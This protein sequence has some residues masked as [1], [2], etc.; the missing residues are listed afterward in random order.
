V[1]SPIEGLKIRQAVCPGVTRAYRGLG[2]WPAGMC[3]RRGWLWIRLRSRSRQRPQIPGSKSNAIDLPF[4]VDVAAEVALLQRRGE[5]ARRIQLLEFIAELAHELR[6]TSV[7]DTWVEAPTILA[8]AHEASGNSRSCGLVRNES[9]WEAAQRIAPLDW[10]LGDPLLLLR[11]LSPERFD[12]VLVAPRVSSRSQVPS[13]PDDP[14]GRVD[15]ADLVLWRAARMVADQGT[16]VFHTSDDFFW[17]QSRRRLWT[18]FA[19]RGLHPRAVISVD[20]VLTQSSSVA[21]SLM[22]FTGEAR[23]Q[24]F[25]GRL[26]RTTSVPA[27]VRNLIEGW[28]DDDPQLGVLTRLETFRGWRPLMLEQELGR[29]FGSSELCALAEIGRIRGRQLRPDVP[30]DP[31]A[32]CVFVPTL[33]VGNVLTEPPDLEGKSGYRLLEIELNPEV[34]QAEYI[35]GLLSSRPGKQLREAVSS[36]SSI[37]HLSATGAEVIRVPVPPISLQVQTIRSAAHLASMEATVARLRDELW[38]RPQDA[39]RML[40][41]LE[42]GATADPVRRWLETLP[43]PLASVLQ[44]SLAPRDPRERLEGLLH[45]YEATAQFCCAVLLSVLKAD[46]DLLAFAKQDIAGAVGRRGDLFGRAEFGLWTRLGRTL[47]QA[48]DRLHEERELRPRLEEAIGPV[49]ELIAQLASQRIWRVLDQARRIRNTRAH[50]GVLTQAELEGSLGTLEVLLSDAEQ[51]LSS[52]FDDIDLART[53]QGRFT[54]SLYVYPRAQRLRGPSDVFAEFELRTRMPLESGHLAFVRRDAAVS[55]VL[56]LLALVRVG[57][58]EGAN[59]NACY[60]F[61]SQLNDDRFAYVSYH[62]EEDPRLKVEEPELRQLALDL[63]TRRTRLPAH[64]NQRRARQR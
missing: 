59:R 15:F 17:T 33:G 47:G 49:A 3:H 28:T 5:P 42:A 61:N 25:V 39:A 26:E 22:L 18:E 44:R 9:L 54:R 1:S 48:I 36:G 53:D 64:V 58:A 60:F 4:L 23:D 50:S 63:K 6:P 2:A 41:E 31:P 34:A 7:I 14:R 10:R 51:A 46:A 40:S 19:Q 16:V 57:G 30:Y 13:E 43:Y 52:G 27:L 35:A 11:D 55:S 56:M 29:M 12:L 45:F 20:P 21:T 24:L 62:F 37:P 32:N 38:R 8:A